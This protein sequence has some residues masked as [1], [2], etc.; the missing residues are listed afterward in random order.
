MTNMSLITKEVIENPFTEGPVDFHEV[1]QSI[2]ILS[3]RDP[4][5]FF[6]FVR[7]LTR[8]IKAE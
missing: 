4:V 2:K 6:R 5:W 3:A 8:V 7:L 1:C